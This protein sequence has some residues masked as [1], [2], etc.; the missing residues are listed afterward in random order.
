MAKISDSAQIRKIFVIGPS[1]IGDAVL[2]TP[3]ISF[4]R[5]RFPSSKLDVLVGP[6]PLPLFVNSATV[7]EI[8]LFDK[9]ISWFEK[10]KLVWALR[11]KKYDLVIDLRYSAIPFFL[12]PRY[13]TSFFMENLSVSMRERYLDRIRPLFS[14]GH[15]QNN[16]NFFN[17]IEK[18]ATL[19]KLMQKSGRSITNDFVVL[20]PGAGSSL[21]CW[22]LTGF[23][24]LIRY[25]DEI[26]KPVVL[27]GGEAEMELGREL[28]QPNSKSPI[29]L[30]GMLTLR[31]LSGL[32][33]EACL[34]V[35]ND[36]SVMHL[37]HELNRPTVSIFGPT[38]EERYGRTGERFRTVRLH[39]DCTPCEEPRCR[40][41]RRVCLDDLPPELVIQACEEL[42]AYATH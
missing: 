22:T 28:E 38:N 36:S 35:T 19:R 10:A 30:I 21:K 18:E 24:R 40:L 9:T 29:N 39:L 13:R 37:S 23:G 33:H 26:E 42:L 16:F 6:R 14:L 17:A 34:V 11:K 41:E 8:V 12:W 7:D 27:V 3:V 31:E 15:A 2:A 32:L 20:A 4:L 5:E 25:F 1:N